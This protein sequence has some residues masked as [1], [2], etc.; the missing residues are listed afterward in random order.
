MAPPGNQDASTGTGIDEILLPSAH[1]GAAS[2]ST[3]L[4]SRIGREAAIANSGP[5][6]AAQIAD[7]NVSDRERRTTVSLLLRSP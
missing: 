1:G 5:Q 3:A 7:P 2:G 6:L 4:S